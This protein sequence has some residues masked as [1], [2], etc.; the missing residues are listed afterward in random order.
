MTIIARICFMKSVLERSFE[1]MAIVVETGTADVSSESGYIAG[2]WASEAVVHRIEAARRLD[3]PYPLALYLLNATYGRSYEDAALYFTRKFGPL[4]IPF[5]SGASFGFSVSEWRA[6]RQ[7][8][9]IAWIE[10]SSSGKSSATKLSEVKSKQALYLP[11]D[12]DSFS[13]EKGRITFSTQRLLT[14][15][16]FEI[17]SISAKRLKICANFG[18]PGY[19]C[20]APF[21]FA[22][23]LREKHCSETCAN[24]ARNRSKLNWWNKNRKGAGR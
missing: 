10:A 18:C 5:S 17:A 3:K 14:Y 19:T 12:G 7:R 22:V 9:H 2:R 16:A 4:T 13:F 24:E 11:L 23:D 6:A 20:I 8:L 1:K 15:A 21:F